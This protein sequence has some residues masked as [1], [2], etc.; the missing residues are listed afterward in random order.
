[1]RCA[2]CCVTKN[3]EKEINYWISWYLTLGFD[4]IILFDDNSNDDSVSQIIRSRGSFDIRL[5][6]V[7]H[8]ATYHALRQVQIYNHVTTTYRE[9]FDWIAFFDADEY[10][11]LYGKNIKNFLNTIGDY[12]SVAFNWANYGWNGHVVRPSGPPVLAYTKHGSSDLFWNRHTK[13]ITKPKAIADNAIG[14]VHASPVPFERTAT[15]SGQPIHWLNGSHAGLTHN[16]PD[17]KGG[18]LIHLQARSME[19]YV[20]REYLRENLRRHSDDPSNAVF[21]DP[22]YNEQTTLI[23]EIYI[24]Q[25]YD[26]IHTMGQ[27]FLHSMLETLEKEYLGLLSLCQNDISENLPIYEEHKNFSEGERNEHWTSDHTD[28]SP[29]PEN[30]FDEKQTRLFLI[31]TLDHLPVGL[32]NGHISLDIHEEGPQLLALAIQGQPFIYLIASDLSVIRMKQDPRVL[33]I[34][35]YETHVDD[36]EKISFTHPRT[37]RYVSARMNSKEVEVGIPR[38]YDWE[39]FCL[40]PL[41]MTPESQELADFL[42]A[43]KS[44]RNFVAKSIASSPVEDA[45]AA[46]F[47]SLSSIQR[48][49]IEKLIGKLPEF[50]Y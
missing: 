47:C 19:N 4:T 25:M 14:Y 32:K 37:R 21:Y 40:K 35:A 20:Q 9:E 7:K 30:F 1:M 42:Y 15:S 29:L 43:T 17:W 34:L 16:A 50:V 41:E 26:V 18:R 12:D 36:A 11:D 24:S 5:N 48:K 2:V 13:V 23:S 49:A 3:E 27:N 22:K 10:L 39:K 44:L 31:E 28:P 8:S 6:K 46:S 38:A 33:N 45:I